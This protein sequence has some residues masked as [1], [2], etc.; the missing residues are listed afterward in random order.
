[1]RQPIAI[2][3]VDQEIIMG[4]VETLPN[5]ADRFIILHNPSQMDG[6]RLKFLEEGVNTIMVSWHQI[7][8]VE[9]LPG[10]GGDIPISFVRE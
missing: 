10:T 3:T 2:H 8:Y 6:K 7:V 5:Q 4:D 1:M 9:L